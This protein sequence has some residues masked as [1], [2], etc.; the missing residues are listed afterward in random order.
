VENIPEADP[1]IALT[2]WTLDRF[3]NLE[4]EVTRG[5]DG[6]PE[7]LEVDPDYGVR[8]VETIE[9]DLKACLP[10]EKLDKLFALRKQRTPAQ[11]GAALEEF[12][13]LEFDMGSATFERLLQAERTEI[14]SSLYWGLRRSSD[15]IFGSVIAS[16]IGLGGP[17]AAR[18]ETEMQW[19]RPDALPKWAARYAV[20]E[21]SQLLPDV[22]E[23]LRGFQVTPVTSAVPT[24]V[25]QY[26]REAS[27][28]YLYGFFAAALILCRS[29]I[30]SGIEERLDQK[31]LRKQLNAIGFN[32]VQA[33]LDLALASGVLNDLTFDMANDIRRSANQAAHGIVPV[34]TDCPA[35]IEQTR[36]VL[37]QLYE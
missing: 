22:V 18:F 29:C 3:L 16:R 34:G 8:S 6:N 35:K 7:R 9:E 25:A 19:R 10:W 33:M 20:R 14:V 2:Q 24:N 23:R 17:T 37:H 28:C 1:L 13:F 21:I 32:K 4:Y 36:T 12:P 15:D 26:A 27:R 31:G 11:V 5:S 30:E